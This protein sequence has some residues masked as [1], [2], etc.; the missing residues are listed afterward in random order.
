M[1]KVDEKK[2]ILVDKINSN[3][4]VPLS[5]SLYGACYTPDSACRCDYSITNPRVN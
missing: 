1:K 4:F 3:K 5:E 2:K